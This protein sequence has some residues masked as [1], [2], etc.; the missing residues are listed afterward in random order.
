M[1]DDPKN[2]T[3]RGPGSRG[4]CHAPPTNAIPKGQTLNPNGAPRKGLSWAESIRLVESLTCAEALELVRRSGGAAEMEAALSRMPPTMPVKILQT[5]AAQ[6]RSIC[7]PSPGLLEFFAN[8]SEG[9]VAD[10]TEG[11][12]VVEIKGLDG[13]VPGKDG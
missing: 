3:K 1:N 2:R 10:R 7:D 8:R 12:L 5:L 13:L 6:V 11:R 9:K 4:S